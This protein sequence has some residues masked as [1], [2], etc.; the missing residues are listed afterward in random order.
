MGG[1]KPPPIFSFSWK[2]DAEE[3]LDPLQRLVYSF[4]H[5]EKW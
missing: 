5:L 3:N 4:I 2:N 1:K